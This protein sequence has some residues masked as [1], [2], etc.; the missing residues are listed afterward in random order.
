MDNIESKLQNGIDLKSQGNVFFKAA[1]YTEALKS[2]HFA[3]CALRGL[4]G[5]AFQ[6]SKPIDPD[7]KRKVQEAMAHVHTNMAAVYLKQGK[8]DKAIAATAK[9]L[10]T[11]HKHVKAM[12]RQAQAYLEL[13][14]FDKAQDVIMRAVT[15]APKDPM[16]RELY[17]S[18]R[19]K[20][21]DSE[22]SSSNE[23][24]AKLKF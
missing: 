15:E 13:K 3:L 19:A 4:D 8:P 12:Y 16:I 18:I 24:K 5:S 6:F 14:S 7:T 2:F 22:K 11:D 21:A 23:L 17:Q 1:N 10:E 9:V 20:I